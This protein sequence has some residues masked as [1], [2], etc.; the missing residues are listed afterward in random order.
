MQRIAILLLADINNYG[1]VLGGGEMIS[2][3]DDEAF[4]A[5]YGE[6]YQG[7]PSDAVLRVS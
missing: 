4:R 1:D 2:P 6:G 3:Y 7:T 5:T